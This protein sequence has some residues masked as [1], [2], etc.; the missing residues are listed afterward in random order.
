MTRNPGIDGLASE[1]VVHLNAFT[2][3]FMQRE[4]V[5]GGRDVEL[6]R[7]DFR[8]VVTLGERPEWTMGEIARQMMVGVSGLTGAV[9]RLA[10]KG[11]AERARSDADRRTVRVRLTREGRR[12]YAQI[13]RIRLRA[14]RDMLAELNAR[15][16]AV[17]LNLMR[18]IGGAGREVGA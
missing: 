16:Q 13:E 5:A 17:F 6:S 7:Q 15:E 8:M 10:A 1:M 2:R 3:R 4:K 12:R 9:D 11:L 18:K 14:A